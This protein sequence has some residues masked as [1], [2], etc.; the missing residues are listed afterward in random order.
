MKQNLRTVSEEDGS[1]GAI[2]QAHAWSILCNDAW[3]L[4]SIHAHTEFHLASPPTEANLWDDAR[5]SN[6]TAPALP[7]G[8]SGTEEGPS[9]S[10][11]AEIVKKLAS[12]CPR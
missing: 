11:L 5:G 1:L 2:L 8:G 12:R 7:G 3:L 6:T 9:K 4:G 10:E